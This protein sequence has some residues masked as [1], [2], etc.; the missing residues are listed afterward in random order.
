MSKIE[1]LYEIIG[2][3][4]RYQLVITFIMFCIGIITD[5]T[6]LLASMMNSAP[7]V[8]YYDNITKMIMT[9]QINYEICKVPFTIDYEKS[10]YNWSVEFNIFCNGTY[11]TILS[12]SLLVGQLFGLICMRF[13]FHNRNKEILL[14]VLVFINCLIFL[15]T[16]VSNFWI[17]SFVLFAQGF[18]Q[19]NTNIITTSIITEITG[20]HHRSYYLT[21]HLSSSLF[22]GIIISYMYHSIYWKYLY[23]ILSGINLIVFILAFI[24]LKKSLID[25]CLESKEKAFN[26]A[27]E[28]AILNKMVLSEDLNIKINSN[29]ND[30]LNLKINEIESSKLDLKMEENKNYNKNEN[31][32]NENKMTYD[33]FRDLFENYYKEN[34][35]DKKL[36]LEEDNK[37]DESIIN[38]EIDVFVEDKIELDE[39]EKINANEQNLQSNIDITTNKNEFKSYLNIVFLAVS[40]IM[41]YMLINIIL[42][43]VKFYTNDD[44]FSIFFSFIVFPEMLLYIVSGY[45]MNNIHLGRRGLHCI[46]I[47]ITVLFRSSFFITGILPMWTYLVI[48]IFNLC[49]RLTIHTIISESSSNKNRLKHF[50]FIF[51][52]KQVFQVPVPFI[53]EFF[54]KLTL[55]IIFCVLSIICIITSLLIEETNRKNLKD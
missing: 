45:L 50:S 7:V 40:T 29:Q 27:I 42:F 47:L 39:N 17:S 11:T 31:I 16:L 44:Y 20:K 15:L 24:F 25:V 41:T 30:N 51:L 19:I 2:N 35:S 1:K 8:K 18:S 32:P 36:K 49:T 13:I 48:R 21:F 22:V 14:Q 9:K 3:N 4:H 10:V 52:L 43:E 12:T 53:L 5:F 34:F 37:V 54:S 6:H 55:N 38:N 23:S 46:I 28:I 26:T 33:Q